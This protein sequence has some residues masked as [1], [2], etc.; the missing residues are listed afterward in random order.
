MTKPVSLEEARKAKG[1]GRRNSTPAKATA[2]GDLHVRVEEI[3]QEFSLVLVGGRAL[4]LRECL[5]YA[6]KEA[7]DFMAISAFRAWLDDERVW[8]G[9][10]ERIVGMG[11]IWLKH[12]QRLKYG[13]VAF[14]P[15]GV[16]AGWFNLWRGFTVEAAAPY[17]DPRDHAKHFPTLYEH[18]LVN[19]ARGSVDLA[20]WVWG[21]FAQMIQ[22]PTIKP[23]T[24]LVMRGLQG[25]GKSKLGESVGALLGPH[26]VKISQPKHLTG[27]FNGHMAA[28]LLLHAD[29]GFWAGDKSA[30]GVLKDLV[31]SDIH[32][33]ERKGVDAVQ[34]R[35][36]IRLYVSSNSDWVVP[37]GPEER[38]FAVLDVGNRNLQDKAFFAQIDAE[39]AD[40]GRSHLLAYLQRFDL[41][42]VD[43]RSIPATEALF[44]QKVASM[45]EL[46]GWWMDR[47]RDGKLLPQHGDWKGEVATDPFYRNYVSYAEQISKARRLSKEQ[48]G[49]GLR[50]LM[51]ATGFRSDQ[52]VWVDEYGPEG[53][54][55]KNTDGS[56]A[57]KRVRGYHVPPLG[58]CRRR[59]CEMFRWNVPWGDEEGVGDS[60]AVTDAAPDPSLAAED[61]GGFELMD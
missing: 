1:K 8:D 25:C 51:P 24:S 27:S 31:T 52:R 29:E 30:E 5:D 54:R 39:L 59:F 49:L 56:W 34:I 38:R 19:I 41:T 46:Q 43:L 9:E 26:W 60:G 18:V 21:W 47:L 10:S 7:I 17:D 44:E 33:I 16:P 23:G 57:R 15:E 50:K 55:V 11:D 3:N 22:Q 61:G 58:E 40:G 32:L 36:L 6:G 13:G 20:R 45:N 4:I 48:F 2:D 12:P 28:C 42:K 37:A 35:N 14:A 53:E